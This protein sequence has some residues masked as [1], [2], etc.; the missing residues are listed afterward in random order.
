MK[1][2]HDMMSQG[3]HSD[4][5]G[6]TMPTSQKSHRYQ[7][8]EVVK[9][10]NKENYHMM[11]KNMKALIGMQKHVKVDSLIDLESSLHYASKTIDA[12][13]NPFSKGS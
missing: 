10:R 2:D 11:I 12:Q 9:S 7:K 5:R 8:M 6:S 13:S 3:M 1:E 4:E